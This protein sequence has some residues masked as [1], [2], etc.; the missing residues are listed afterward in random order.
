MRTSEVEGKKERRWKDIPWSWI[1]RCNIVK[2]AILLK[3]MYM[4][5]AIC[6][7]ILMTFFIKMENS[8]L[9]FKWKHNRPQISKA[10]LRQ[11]NNAGGNTILDF[12]LSY[13]DIVIK[14]A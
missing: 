13:R 9:K 3:A 6:T 12:K 11:N 5:N 8:I 10:I 14:T 1:G 2:M 7:K 4:F